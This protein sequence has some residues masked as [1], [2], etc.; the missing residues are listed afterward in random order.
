MNWKIVFILLTLFLTG[1]TEKPQ[2]DGSA[3][4]GQN[5]PAEKTIWT[6]LASWTDVSADYGDLPRYINVYKSPSQ[7]NG[8]NAVAYVAV[9]DMTYAE[10]D[11]WS[12]TDP[13]GDGSD[14]SFK[15]PTKVY[16]ETSAPIVINAGFFYASGS[17]TYASSLAVRDSRVLTYN[18]NYAVYDWGVTPY[19]MRYPT[20]AAFREDVDGTFDACYV[21]SGSFGHYMYQSAANNS[22]S[23][24]TSMTPST[25]YPSGGKPFAAV[26]AIGGGPLLINKGKFVDSYEK[27]LFNGPNGIA[28]D[29]AQPRTAIGVTADRQLVLF[30]CEGRNVTPGVSGFTTADVAN[31]LLDLC[32]TEAVNLDGGGSSCMLVNG[33]ETIKVSDG[34]QRP[35]GS[36]IMIR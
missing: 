1:C 35:V 29:S 8:S 11:I 7:L 14:E 9:A 16:S 27:E 31:I 2:T 33:K 26:T 30:V 20:R 19:D 3:G 12:I 24:T 25:S 6:A 36:T 23:K 34:S 5:P 32:C 22:W 17:K 18:I 28:P 10:W 21:Y 4:G 15:T 13:E